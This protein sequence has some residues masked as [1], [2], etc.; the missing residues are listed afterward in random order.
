MLARIL[1]E[2]GLTPLPADGPILATR[3]YS[4][5][6]E[7]LGYFGIDAIYEF[8]AASATLAFGCSD[9]THTTNVAVARGTAIVK[10]THTGDEMLAHVRLGRV[11][12][13]RWTTADGTALEAIV[14]FLP[15][16]GGRAN[17]VSPHGGLEAKDQLGFGALTHHRGARIR[18][19]VTPVPVDRRATVRHT[20]RRSSSISATPP[21][22]MSMPQ[23]PKR[24]A[25]GW[26]DPK[27]LAIFRWSAGGFRTSRTLTRPRAIALQSK[28]PVLP[29]G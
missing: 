3:I 28:A 21:A 2:P 23:R 9:T 10:L 25:Q 27:R 16:T 29:N 13:R 1:R 4:I 7:Q 5:A 6:S 19:D 8:A 20:C 14:T 26:A 22:V 11:I 18:G 12:R 24:I 15:P 17:L